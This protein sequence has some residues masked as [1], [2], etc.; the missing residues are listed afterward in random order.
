MGFPLQRPRRL[1]RTAALRRSFA[2]TRLSPA[3]LILPLF[4]KEGI[5]EPIAVP[6]M[7]GVYQHTLESLRKAANEAVQAG[8]GGVILFGI[9]A[10]KDGSGS[11][12]DAADGIV[13]VALRELGRDLA[14]AAILMA[15]LCL[16]EYTDHGH[17]GPLN[18]DGEVDNDATI[19]RYADVAVSQAKW[20]VDSV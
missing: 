6:S 12:A 4:I 7:P 13:Q 14:D 10:T 11:G 3:D 8:V 15:D 9:P 5:D 20:R 16:C 19:A 2:E 18:V 1:R 17:C